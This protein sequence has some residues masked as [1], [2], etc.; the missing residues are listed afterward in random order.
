M[1][2]KQLLPDPFDYFK[3]LN[4]KEII[5]VKILETLDNFIKVAAEGSPLQILIKKN[6]IAV[7]K[8]DQRTNRFNKGDK[9][10]C[11][12]QSIH[13]VIANIL[14]PSVLL[15]LKAEFFFLSQNVEM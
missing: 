13:M 15:Y 3:N 11:L 6:Q 14:F 9:V 8:E 7:D 1:G 5:T 12:L 2:L 10:D 4:T